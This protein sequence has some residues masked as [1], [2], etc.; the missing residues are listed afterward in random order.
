MPKYT[1]GQHVIYASKK[2]YKLFYEERGY[3]LLKDENVALE[4]IVEAKETETEV[5]ETDDFYD[6]DVESISLDM[7][8]SM[9]LSAQLGLLSYDQLKAKAKELGITGNHKREKLVEMIL[10]AL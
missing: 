4:P 7:E 5:I 10:D 8:G 1:N 3:Q 2:A 6:E 9:P